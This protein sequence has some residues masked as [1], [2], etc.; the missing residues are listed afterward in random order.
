MISV[1][2]YVLVLI[3]IFGLIIY[4]I[5]LLPLTAPFKQIAYVIVTIIIILILLSLI[6]LLPLGTPHLVL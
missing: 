3:V 4:C 2:I 6:G 1:L 5:Q